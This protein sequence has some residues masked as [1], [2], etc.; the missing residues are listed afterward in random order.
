MTQQQAVV[1]PERFSSGMTYSQYME[2]ISRNREKFEFNYGETQL[3]A[4][5]AA[6]FSDLAS[7][8]G[9]AARVLVLGE[10]WCP[11]VFRGLPVMARIAEAAGM[12]LRMFPRDDN[13]DIMSHF[14]KGGEHQ[15]IPT[16]VFYTSSHDYIAHWI[17]RPAKANA[18][19]DQVRRMFDGLDPQKDRD[20]MREINNDFQR[21]PVWASWRQETVREL[22]ELLEKE[23]P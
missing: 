14:L 22:R 18:E 5:D 20:K 6:A 3:T 9:G 15:S 16:F 17:E 2:K 1:T 21:G 13:M 4:E 7:K 12:D 23:C 11:D 8:K 10:D 19:I